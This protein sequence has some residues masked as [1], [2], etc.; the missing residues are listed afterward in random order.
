MVDKK[1]TSTLQ[2]Y[3]EQIQSLNTE[4]EKLQQRRSVEMFF[5]FDIVNSS[6]YKTLN[7]TGW[8]QVI[9]TLFARIQERVAKK[10]PSAE[11]WKILGDEVI[12]IVSVLEKQDI[13]IYIDSVFEILN[14][15]VSQLKTGTFFEDQELRGLDQNLLKMQNIISL[16]A[17]AWIAIIGE[18]I[19]PEKYD[20]LMKR[21]KLQEGYEI[22]EFLGN[23]ID[24]GFRIKENTQ[25]K[26]LVISYELAYILS[27]NTDYLKNINIITYKALKGIW[28]NHLYPIIWYHDKKIAQEKSLED[29]FYYDER[30]NS[31]LVNAYFTN[32]KDPF[33]QRK[34]YKDVDYALNKILTDQQLKDK[35]LKID[36]VIE[37][38]QSD[39]KHLLDP[40]F[41]LRLHCVAVCFER[42]KK[43]I[44]IM[45]RSENRKKLAG[46]WE[47]GCAKGSL[48]KSLVEQIEEDYWLDFGIRIKVVCNK[49][50][51]DIQPVPLAVYEVE[52]ELGKDKG[53][54]TLAEIMEDVDVEGFRGEKHSRIRWIEEDEV[55]QF[56]EPA[57]DDFHHTLNMVFHW[58]G[59]SEI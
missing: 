39:I 27:K 25:D 5:S 14:Q 55:E 40:K 51:K 23:D 49:D 50:R 4:K 45:K 35:F 34:M 26:R 31:K 58:L 15:T 56:S 20:N 52:G 1:F 53:I 11:M 33:L 47:F 43:K 44:L 21:F 10:M 29:S 22:F 46:L 7:F 42:S 30:K 57:V 17:A 24:T 13:F 2:K 12:F 19:K 38:S 8:S 16:K 37:E 28:Q 59:K 48:E 54:I 18:E 9:I 36:R 41:L 6:S 32:R 3:S